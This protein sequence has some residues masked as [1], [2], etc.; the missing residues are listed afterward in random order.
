MRTK[1]AF[2]A[3]F[4]VLGVLAVSLPSAHAFRFG[5]RVEKKF[6]KRSSYR[7]SSIRTFRPKRVYDVPAGTTASQEGNRVTL[8]RPDKTQ[9]EFK[10]KSGCFV[11]PL[12]NKLWV[13]NTKEGNS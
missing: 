9:I 7:Y 6:H 3:T 5:A 4:V 10:A 11:A 1:K 8:F 2:V 13:I 12:G